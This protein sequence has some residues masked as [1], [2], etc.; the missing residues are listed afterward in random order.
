MCYT[1]HHFVLRRRLRTVHADISASTALQMEAATQRVS[2]EV[3]SAVYTEAF[4]DSQRMTP[5]STRLMLMSGVVHWRH[6]W[7]LER[8]LR[9]LLAL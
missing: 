8:R 3:A 6:A 1:L 2:P 4:M 9:C 5:S 7:L